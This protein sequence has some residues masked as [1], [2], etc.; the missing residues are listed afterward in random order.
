MSLDNK[1]RVI[2]KYDNKVGITDP[3]IAYY[4]EQYLHHIN[5]LYPVIVRVYNELSQLET[6]PLL[7]MFKIEDDILQPAKSYED[8]INDIYD[9]IILINKK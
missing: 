8:L 7:E 9:G 4:K 3:I 5:W 6:M 2:A 1:I